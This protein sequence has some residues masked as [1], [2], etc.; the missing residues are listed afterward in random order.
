MA[1]ANPEALGAQRLW[2]EWNLCTN[3]YPSPEF[4]E[5]N[6]FVPESTVFLAGYPTDFKPNT[7]TCNEVTTRFG[8][9]GTGKQ[10]I[11][12]PLVNYV[13][14]DGVDD[15]ELGLCGSN[16]SEQAL[17]LKYAYANDFVSYYNNETT[18]DLL[19]YT[20]DDVNQTAIFIYDN[21]TYYLEGCTDGRTTLEYFTLLGFPE[22]DTC[23]KEPHQKFNGLDAFPMFGWFGNDTREWVD[24]ETHTYEFGSTGPWFCIT[25]K[26]IL[27]A[28]AECTG[29]FGPGF[30]PLLRLQR[31]LRFLFG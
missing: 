23:D 6:E 30:C 29:I 27:T 24:G 11:F 15:Y 14:L 28:R 2:W 5:P 16:T 22:G 17:A 26:Y 7:T 20:I 9:I 3:A 18:K 21:R 8:E 4:T 25:A 13:S 31:F 12:F 1:E 10:T 19:L